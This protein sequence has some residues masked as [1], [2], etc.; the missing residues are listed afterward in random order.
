MGQIRSWQAIITRKK[1]RPTRGTNRTNYLV[2]TVVMFALRRVSLY[3]RRYNWL[4]R[5][6]FIEQNKTKV[7]VAT[8][9]LAL[10]ALLIPGLFRHTVLPYYQPLHKYAL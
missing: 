2:A 5:S 6:G 7:C 3:F 8:A 4:D 10:T 9:V 1:R